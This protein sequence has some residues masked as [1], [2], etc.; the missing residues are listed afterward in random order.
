MSLGNAP[1]RLIRWGALGLGITLAVAVLCAINP[2]PNVARREI[3]LPDPWAGRAFAA[4]SYIR[5]TFYGTFGRT[6]V[7]LTRT[8]RYPE[9]ER[10]WPDR[11]T[12]D[13]P[14]WVHSA[15]AREFGGQWRSE[16]LVI[17]AAGWPL[18]C[19]IGTTRYPEWPEMTP[20]F[21]RGGIRLS[22]PE[23]AHLGAGLLAVGPWWAG[24]AANALLYG[25]ILWGI[26]AAWGYA[27]ARSRKANA[28]CVGCGY[29][30]STTPPG[31]CPECGMMGG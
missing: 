21:D 5:G 22:Q 29:D 6:Q 10:V 23:R 14:P 28:R 20:Y 12:R 16:Q 30:R 8:A 24:V 27:R 11:L 13:I 19:L 17:D 18:R 9:D 15:A 4:D 7:I 3:K 1:L 2:V 25:G 31:P 26:S